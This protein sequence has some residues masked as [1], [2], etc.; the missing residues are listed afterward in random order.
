MRDQAP[1]PSEPLILVSDEELIERVKSG[2]AEAFECLVERY[3]AAALNLA[4]GFLGDAHEAEDLAQE[5]FLRVYR[6]A[7]SYRPLASFKTWFYHILGNLCRNAIKKHKPEYWEEPP[8]L[9]STA[10]HPLRD[11]ERHELQQAISR[12]LIQLPPNQRLAFILC[13]YEGLSYAEAAASL[14]LS[15]KA[16]DSLLLRARQNLRR[17]LAAF[18]ANISV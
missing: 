12:A 16:I 17:E 8:E 15:V 9:P 4:Y 3:Q 14:D 1:A 5:A 7:D 6:H 10:S 13:H 11:V 2:N 18:N